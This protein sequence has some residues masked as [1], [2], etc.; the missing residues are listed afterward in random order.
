MNNIVIEHNPFTIE[1]NFYVDGK[2]LNGNNVLANF[3]HRRLQLWVD[4]LPKA[5]YEFFN[6][7]VDVKIDGDHTIK[8]KIVSNLQSAIT[9]KSCE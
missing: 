7:D 3:K 5:L 4:Q 6:Q 1:T 8:S 9:L 2:E